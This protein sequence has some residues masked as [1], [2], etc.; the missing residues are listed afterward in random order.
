MRKSFLVIAVM[1]VSI[2]ATLFAPQIQA[3][4][5]APQPTQSPAAGAPAS[6]C[7]AAPAPPPAIPSTVSPVTVDIKGTATA[8]VP[9]CPSEIQIHLMPGSTVLPLTAD[10]TPTE[11]SHG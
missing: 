10:S 3:R 2:F 4:Q 7:P 1:C 8:P 9:G 11:G 5:P 6:T